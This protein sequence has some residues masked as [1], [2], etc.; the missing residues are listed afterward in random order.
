MRHLNK[1]EK[2][3]ILEELGVNT[4]PCENSRINA[5]KN[6]SKPYEKSMLE[7]ALERIE[8]F[9]KSCDAGYRTIKEREE[10]D[11]EEV[12]EWYGGD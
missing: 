5:P 10:E 1:T 2:Y 12:S 7:I 3:D 4:E 6:M 11:E 9:G 8:K